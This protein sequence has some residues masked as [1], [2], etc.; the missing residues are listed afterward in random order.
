MYRRTI[1]ML[2]L[3]TLA[4]IVPAA[5]AAEQAPPP[6]VEWIGKDAVLVVEMSHPQALLDLALGSKVA[7]AVAGVPG[8]Q[9][10][11]SGPQFQQLLG[12]VKYL[13]LRLG[14]DWQ[15]S[16]RRLVEGGVTWAAY[17]DGGSLL[18]VEAADGRMLEKLH[19]VF[20]AIAKGEAAKHGRKDPVASS[21]YQGVTLWTL[22]E[23][24]TH[25]IVGKRLLLSNRMEVV[26]AALDL[27]GQS[28]ERSVTALPAYQAAKKAVGSEAAATAFVNLAMLKQHPG[29]QKAL[30]QQDANP[31][32]VLLFAGVIEALQ[33]SD[34]LALGLRVE[35]DTLTLRAIA[36]AKPAGSDTAASFTRPRQSG[37]GAL[38]NLAVPRRIAAVSLFRDLHG[39][40]AAKDKLFPERTSGLIFFENMMGIFFTGRDLTEEVFADI[41]PEMRLVVARQE[42]DPAI[43]TPQI[44][45]PAFATILRVRHPKEFGEVI[46]EAWQ[47]ALGLINVTSGQKAQPGLIIDRE[48]HSDT[49][50]TVARF[51]TAGKKDKA[52]VDVRYNFRP[53]LAKVGDYVV[54]SS[55]DGLAKDLIDALKKESAGAVQPAAQAHSLVAM[56]NAALAAILT[57]NRQALV[58]QNMVEKGTTQEQAE[59]QV[60]LL[61]TVLKYLGAVDLDMGRRDG[62]VQASLKVK[63]N[64]GD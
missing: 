19:E 54:L 35:G 44:Q 51:S 32:A 7:R 33:Q 2:G 37:E 22:G 50:Y 4:L 13:E 42:Y 48:T 63:L 59:G 40:Y 30:K 8:Y 61:T 60:D 64:L 5:L 56:D 14:N 25:A 18:I 53:A 36:D 47:K 21:N 17:P 6:A 12:L 58:R 39:F 46:E 31:L 62:Q 28:A 34:W 11:V 1:V 24:E 55:T 43:G 38:P 45:L 57:A 26:K 10:A 41:R 3:A 9:K 27:R 29:V 20:Q 49:R 52:E 23:N 16:V 15:T